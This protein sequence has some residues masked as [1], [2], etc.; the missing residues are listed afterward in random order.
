MGFAIRLDSHYIFVDPCVTEWPDMPY[1]SGGKLVGT[2]KVGLHEFPLGADE[3]DRADLILYTHDHSD[4]LDR[5][6]LPRLVELRS[7]IWA[8]EQGVQS[9]LEE[10]VPKGQV[11]VARVCSSLRKDSY[12]V[13]FIR[14]RHA[15]AGGSCDLDL[16]WYYKDVQDQDACSCGYL[17]KTRYGNIYHPGDTY[18]LQDS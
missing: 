5:G 11:H 18:Y 1:A 16:K 3:F 8:P 10:G 9:I 13:E 4:H 7:E 14:A 2:T 17:V 6:L 12:M 15:S